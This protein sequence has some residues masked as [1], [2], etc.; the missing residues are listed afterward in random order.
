M[1][2]IPTLEGLAAVP[3]FLQTQG[4]VIP[5]TTNGIIDAEKFTRPIPYLGIGPNWKGRFVQKETLWQQK[6]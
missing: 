5:L 4:D 3:C 1:R 2:V 6:E